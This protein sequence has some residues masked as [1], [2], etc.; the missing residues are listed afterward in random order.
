MDWLDNNSE[1]SF[2][3]DIGDF[4]VERGILLADITEAKYL[5]KTNKSDL[6][7]GAVVNLTLGSGLTK[8][9]GA[10]ESDA[11]ITVQFRKFGFRSI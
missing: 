5:V 2:A 4:I 8:V 7:S 3:I 11:T 1:D 9:A 10:T 6:D